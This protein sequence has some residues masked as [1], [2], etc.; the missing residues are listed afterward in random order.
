MQY[1]PNPSDLL[2]R[3]GECL[4]G[5]RWLMRLARD[6]DVSDDILSR[7]MSGKTKFPADHRVLKRAI[8][9]LR[10]KA[11]ELTSVADEIERGNQ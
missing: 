1:L 4:Y 9:F 2:A 11:R 10:A 3:A 7:W 6:L 5:S 8:I